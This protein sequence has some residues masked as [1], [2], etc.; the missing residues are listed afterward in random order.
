MYL[1]CPKVLEKVSCRPPLLSFPIDLAHRTPY[2]R[3]SSV[4][5]T[6]KKPVSPGQC[7]YDYIMRDILGLFEGCLLDT[8]AL[9]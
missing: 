1:R 7:K 8:H 9:M 4:N 3:D 5:R 2:Q 6:V